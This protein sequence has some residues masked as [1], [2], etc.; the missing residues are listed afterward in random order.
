MGERFDR[1]V[2]VDWSAAARPVSGP[3]SIWIAVLDAASS[4][5]PRLSNP[6]TRRRAEGE[7]ADLVADSSRT[8]VAIDA[9]FG[10]P[11]GTARWFGLA[12]EPPWSAMWRH[13]DE[14]LR[15]D[16]ANANDRFAVAAALNCGAPDRFGSGPFWGCPASMRL[17]GLGPRKPGSSPLPE[18]RLAEQRLRA[19][20]RRPASAWQLTG[21]G[22]VGSQTLTLL[23][24][25]HRLHTAGAIDVWPF[26]TGLTMPPSGRPLVVETW[27][28]AFDLDLSSHPVRDAAQVA[29]V[30]RRLAVVDADGELATW[31]APD[32]SDEERAVV[33][34]EEGWVLA[35]TIRTAPAV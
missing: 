29:G 2:V 12:G 30:A 7:I 16:E 32:M 34:S 25:L 4:T 13:L 18:L 14:H 23:P 28:T 21:A 1:Y 35:S 15:D 10:Y 31:F 17:D 19:A 3:N 27:P 22:S 33:E 5:E 6:T 9:S 24:V 8:L 11:A 20:G 26:T